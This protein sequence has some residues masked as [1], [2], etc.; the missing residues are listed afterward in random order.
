MISAL[1]ERLVKSAVADSKI[2]LDEPMEFKL[3]LT[4]MALAGLITEDA[5]LITKAKT[6][7]LNLCKLDKW[8]RGDHGRICDLWCSALAS[9]AALSYN[10]LKDRLSSYERAQVLLAI[11]SKAVDLYSADVARNSWHVM[12]THNWGGVVNGNMLICALALENDLL[13]VCSVKSSSQ[14][15]LPNF[16]AHFPN[17]GGWDEGIAYLWYGLEV[18]AFAAFLGETAPNPS[19]SNT[20]HWVRIFTSPA[21]TVANFSDCNERVHASSAA[22]FLAYQYN[23][24]E[25]LELWK[26]AIDSGRSISVEDLIYANALP[27]RMKS[28][29]RAVPD[30][31]IDNYINW[32]AIRSADGTT[33][34]AVK[35][36]SLR[37]NHSQIDLGSFVLV[38]NGK[39]VF[40]DPGCP[41]PYPPDYFNPLK[42]Y[43]SPYVQQESHNSVFIKQE[44]QIVQDNLVLESNGSS[45]ITF[46]LNK[47]SG[48]WRRTIKLDGNTLSVVDEFEPKQKWSATF[49]F[50]MHN[51][52]LAEAPSFIE[53][54]QPV[55]ESGSLHTLARKTVNT[56]PDKIITLQINAEIA[57]PTV[58]RWEL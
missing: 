42:R 20:A 16:W 14:K 55:V 19:C 5:A 17:S 51:S 23:D 38:R 43:K 12:N 27:G 49:S 25:A 47:Q 37:A 39:V 31:F 35:G 29:M 36:G 1:R 56:I 33:W 53:E 9:E 58:V 10:W 44:P 28:A 52:F 8:Y 54:I 41:Q 6:E 4:R 30:R 26:S 15:L 48:S 21:N 18:P 13:E 45:G 24:P 3:R 50:S 11:K 46:K 7:L 34:C 32:G 40:C 22:G 2:K 57:K